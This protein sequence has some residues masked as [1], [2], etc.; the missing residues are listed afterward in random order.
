MAKQRIFKR[1]SKK[2]KKVLEMAETYDVEFKESGNNFKGEDLVS[3]ANS[4]Y[5][6]TILIGVK[7]IKDKD[8]NQKGK[9]VG[10]SVGDKEKLS[11]ISKA[12]Q[13]SPPVDLEVFIENMN[14]T[15]FF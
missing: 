9:V 5:G 12:Q 3:F 8:G 11:L 13:C 6:G 14:T 2:A 4:E 1:I 15:P 7:E 10:C